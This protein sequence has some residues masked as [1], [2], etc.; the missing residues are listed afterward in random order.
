M[1]RPVV[2]LSHC[3]ADEA[4]RYD[5]EALRDPVVAMLAP[6]VTFRPVCPEI[7]IGLGVPRDPVHLVE[8]GSGVAMVQPSTGLD[9]T[10][11]MHAFAARFLTSL[12]PVDGFLLKGRSPSC[13]ISETKVFDRRGERVV[14]RGDGLF[15]AAALLAFAG[16]A[17][18]AED[19]LGDVT[20]RDRFLTRVFASARLRA[21]RSTAGLAHL[22]AEDGT[23]LLARSKPAMRA[24]GRIVASA[25]G[26][27]FAG[28]LS[29]YRE[30][31]SR[32]LAR[33]ARAAMRRSDRLPFDPYPAA[34]AAR[35]RVG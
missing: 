6:F 33:P 17:V 16:T 18:E 31:I 11:R 5:G 22:H 24:L 32:A 23:L 34:L 2:V 10:E 13:G 25:E 15:A 19:R 12:G 3:L 27:P 21:V 1:T 9:L 8:C 4:C 14:R 20:I 30:E 26:L 28:V 35:L 7:A 29:R